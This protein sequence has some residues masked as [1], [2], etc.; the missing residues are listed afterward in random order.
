M[1]VTAPFQNK[2]LGKEPV[3]NHYAINHSQTK[4]ED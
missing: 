1:T 3:V 2:Q 4:E